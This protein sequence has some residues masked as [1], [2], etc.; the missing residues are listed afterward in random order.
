MHHR[1]HAVENRLKTNQPE[2]VER[3]RTQAGQR[4][5]AIAPVAVA[6]LVE[7]GVADPVPAIDGVVRRLVRNRWV[8]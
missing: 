7:L 3:C 5:S 8:A 6:I 2:Q 1:L 4:T